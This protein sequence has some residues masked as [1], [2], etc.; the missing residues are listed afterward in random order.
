LLVQQRAILET[1]IPTVDAADRPSLDAQ[2]Q[3]PATLAVIAAAVV[4]GHES[5]SEG[6]RT[7]RGVRAE[8]VMP[9][10]GENGAARRAETETD[11]E[12]DSETAAVVGREGR[13]CCY[14]II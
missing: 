14:S 6:E 5:E 2:T 12:T 9:H 10:A 11:S 4:S 7:E 3:T 1:G 13:G 8:V